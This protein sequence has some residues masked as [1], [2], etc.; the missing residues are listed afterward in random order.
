MPLVAIKGDG[1]E[2][3]HGGGVLVRKGKKMHI[4]YSATENFNS[5]CWNCRFVFVCSVI[6]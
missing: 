5:Y 4:Q 2:A 6:H 1:V 3:G